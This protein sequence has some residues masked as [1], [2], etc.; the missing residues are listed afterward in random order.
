MIL[1]SPTNI[2][3]PTKFSPANQRSNDQRRR[4]AVSIAGTNR[5]RSFS[6]IPR[7]EFGV[8]NETELAPFPSPISSIDSTCPL[9]ALMVSHLGSVSATTPAPNVLSAAIGGLKF[10]E[11][12]RTFAA[13]LFRAFAS[14]W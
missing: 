6:G 2:A 12:F 10:T 1:F 3:T 4:T 9:V 8:S 11:L 14:T 5:D 13:K 7:F